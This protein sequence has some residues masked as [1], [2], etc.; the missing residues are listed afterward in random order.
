MT[1]VIAARWAPA[2]VR[3]AC[4]TD[5]PAIRDMLFR[6]S[7]AAL[8]DRT[9]GG[10]RPEPLVSAVRRNVVEARGVV[11]VAVRD[12]LVVGCLELVECGPASTADLAV[13]VEDAWQGKGIGGTLLSAAQ[14]LVRG[15]GI[16]A[17]TFSVEAA[18]TR[19]RRLMTGF[20]GRDPAARVEGEW[21]DGVF[22]VTWRRASAS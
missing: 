19:A 13:L 21:H 12:R 9:H 17:V 14:P 3:V 7:P 15:L 16:D 20:L 2:G 11:L 22:E 1:S 6:C 5:L 4:A 10:V 18:N 8:R